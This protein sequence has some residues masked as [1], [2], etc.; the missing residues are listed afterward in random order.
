MHKCHFNI[1]IRVEVIKVDSMC[2]RLGKGVTRE[3]IEK[4]SQSSAIFITSGKLSNEYY[5]LLLI[6]FGAR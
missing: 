5:C 6:F 3:Y 2:A 1:N 4:A